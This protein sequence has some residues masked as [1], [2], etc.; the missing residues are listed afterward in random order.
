MTAVNFDIPP[1]ACDCHV[2]VFGDPVRFPFA[3]E[4]V[5]T[6]PPAS[7]EELLA[8]QA[9]LRL[10]RVVVVQPSVYGTDNSCTLDAVRRMGARARA[11]AV[12]DETA[13]RAALEDMA[14]A[15]VRGVRLNLETNTGGRIEPDAA[16]AMLAATAEQIRGLGWHVQIYT[17]PHLIA[18][19][20]D[21]LAQLSFPVVFDHFGGAAATQ[22]P[23][24][25]GFDALLEL[26]RS[27]RVHVKISGAYRASQQAPDLPT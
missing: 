6:P 19:L 20:K 13:S 26:V 27:G 23:S 12:I 22:G 14:A 9:A 21:H 10:E 15:G 16:K 11:V 2:H 17:R 4:R 24:Q 1:G 25:A 7:V 18:A 5:Y 3:Q 8:L